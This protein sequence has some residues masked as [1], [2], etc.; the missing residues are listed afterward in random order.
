[1]A[2]KE[3]LK[4]ILDGLRRGG[5]IAANM[6]VDL[7]ALRKGCKMMLVPLEEIGTTEQ[8][9]AAIERSIKLK[10]QNS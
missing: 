1:M 2:S 3:E 6:K 5:Y 7:D 9:L 10:L 4:Q 8:E